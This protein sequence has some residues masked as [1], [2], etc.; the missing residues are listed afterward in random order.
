M[1]GICGIA[2]SDPRARPIGMATLAAMTSAI[3]HRGPDEAGHGIHAVSRW[4]CAA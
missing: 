1:C 3:E 4:A 2:A